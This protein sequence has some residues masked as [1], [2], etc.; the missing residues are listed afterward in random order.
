M[1][2]NIKRKN[3]RSLKIYGRK[4]PY[5]DDEIGQ[6]P[7]TRCGEPA[8]TQWSICADGNKHRPVC[9]QC[10][11]ALNELVL[12]WMG[13]RDVDELI[14]TYKKGVAPNE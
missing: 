1:S 9:L 14:A 3:Q 6:Y 11:I 7:C 5:T 2:K 4:R 8:Q 13:F 12:Q 10:D